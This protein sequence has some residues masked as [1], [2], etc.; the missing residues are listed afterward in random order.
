ML[1]KISQLTSAAPSIA[2]YNQPMATPLGMVI[3]MYEF[4]V[5]DS[6][7]KDA[8]YNYHAPLYVTTLVFLK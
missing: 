5:S 2:S 4:Q 6:H 3:E 8:S 7:I 1:D